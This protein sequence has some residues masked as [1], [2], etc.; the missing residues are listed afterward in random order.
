MFPLLIP[1]RPRNCAEVKVGSPVSIECDAKKGEIH[2][3]QELATKTFTYDKVFGPHSKQI[4]V[5]RSVVAPLL[6][7]VLMGY[8]CTVFA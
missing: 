5:Y 7:E 3:K 8:N 6:D 4:E 1:Q 2:A